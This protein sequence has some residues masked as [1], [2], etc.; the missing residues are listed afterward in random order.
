ML[1]GQTRRFARK[2]IRSYGFQRTV[3]P[4]IADVVRS[5]EIDLV[6]DVGA[7]D[8]DFARDLR[9]AGYSGKIVSFEPAT[10]AYQRLANAAKNDPGWDTIQL[11]IGDEDGMLQ[12]S[13]SAIDVYSSFKQPSLAGRV[14][15]GSREIR[16]EDVPV[17]RLDT[18]LRKSPQY[19]GRIYLKIDTQGFEMEV[20]QG[21]GDRLSDLAAVQAELGLVRLYDDQEDWLTV[22]QWMRSRQFEVATMICNSV[23]P[24]AGQAVEYDVVF[25]NRSHS[26]ANTF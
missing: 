20:L 8:G 11:A 23:D 22:I 21:V 7:N 19:A 6:L 5:R 4:T 24:A 9:D 17:S 15:P 12:L 26:S 18:F 13:I 14:A 16:T 3:A 10:A 2:L 25:T 1:T